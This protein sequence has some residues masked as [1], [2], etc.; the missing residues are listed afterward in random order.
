MIDV[1]WTDEGQRIIHYKFQQGW[2]WEDLYAAESQSLEMAA[3]VAPQPVHIVLDL[4]ESQV[5][6]HNALSHITVVMKRQPPNLASVMFIGANAFVK[7]LVNMM[8]RLR[9]NGKT[10]MI[11]VTTEAE[12]QSRIKAIN[13]VGSASQ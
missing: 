6:P 8:E 4:R 11:Y 7:V 9:L 1:T 3:S 2:S 5:I 10:P 12:L 13:D